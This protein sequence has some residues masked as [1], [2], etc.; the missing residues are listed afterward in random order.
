MRTSSQSSRVG[1]ARHVPLLDWGRSYGPAL[2][3][4]DLVAGLT[5]AVMLIPQAMAYAALAGMPPVTGL[6]ASMVPLLIYAVLGTSGQL[7][8]GPVAI[9]ALLTA[10]G[11][12]PLAGGEPGRYVALAALLAVLVGVIQAALGVL[13]LGAL[14]NFMSHA[15]ISGFTS[16]AAIVIATSQVPALLGVDVA[17][18]GG[19]LETVAGV[20]RAAGDTNLVTLAIAGAA[21]LLLA[22]GRRRAPRA[23]V[24]LL[25]VAAATAV[26]AALGLDRVGVDILR[27]VPAGLP[28]PALPTLS[29]ASVRALLP[30]AVT[31]AVISYMEGISVAKAIAAKTRQV[32]DAD[33]ELIATG[34][35]NIAAGLFQSFPVAGGFS[36]TAV[37]YQAG[38]R[39]GVASAVT[40]VVIA[41]AV[42]AF[43]PLFFFLPRAVL[44]AVIVVAVLGLIDVRGGRETWRVRPADGVTLAI[45]FGGTLLLGVEAGIA[46]GVTVSLV[47]FV[48]RTANPHTAELGRVEG[49]TFLR[50][51]ARYP[52]RTDPQV[53]ILR[54][55]G[56]LYFANAKFLED[57]MLMLPS[58]R[59]E[60]RHVVL[61]AAAVGDMD[62]SGAHALAEVDARLTEQGVT[63]HLATV[64]GPVRD[65]LA[66]ADVLRC[67]IEEG[68]VHPGVDDAVRALRLPPHSPLHGIGAGEHPPAQVL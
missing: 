14:V 68:R 43:T 41:V 51:V 19:W 65:I 5:V 44:A 56:P 26:V 60:L 40:A 24:A 48:W 59:P 36:R 66:R 32:I 10:S 21:V 57:R 8:V 39:T 18:N 49:T 28:T 25:V 42:L 45:T 67:M 16:A 55:D 35:A 1:L 38:A 54:I 9:T 31:I 22:A 33:Q 47:M 23:P 62:A 50:N 20:T 3:R 4:S 27:E 63:L 2:F 7:A 52:T 53:A 64:R 37:N 12:A 46:I 13:R 58:T 29:L 34:A 17:G 11:L 15:V 6:Y 61:D 30:T